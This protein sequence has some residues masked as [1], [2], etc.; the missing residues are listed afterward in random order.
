LWI[1]N[2]EWAAWKENEVLSMMEL[3]S[4]EKLCQYMQFPHIQK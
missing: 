4:A 2:A 3:F 1:S